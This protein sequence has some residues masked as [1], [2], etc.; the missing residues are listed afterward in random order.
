MKKYKYNY[1]LVGGGLFNAI[2]AYKA[3]QNN[4]KCLVVEKRSHLGGNVYCQTIE[5]INVH[6]YGAHIF[7]TKD[8]FVWEFMQTLCQFNHYINSPLA[9]YQD[10]IYN[11][12]FNMNTFYQLWGVK[13]P[14]EAMHKIES[15]QIEINNP[16]NL[17]EQALSLVGYD[18]Y[19]KLIKGYTEKQWGTEASKLPAFIINRIPLRFTFNNNYFEDPYQGI[20]IGG[21]TPI[22]EKCFAHSDIL[23]N[24]NFT[25]DRSLKDLAK[26]TIY[27][28][29]IDEYYSYKYGALEY[30]SLKFEERVLDTENFQGNAV[31]NYTEQNVPHTRI[32]EH[33]HFE[34]GTQPKTVISIE[35]PCKWDKKS[36]P[37]Y[38]INTQHNNLLYAKY[39]ELATKEDNIYFAGRLGTYQYNDMDKT[40]HDAL[41]LYE[42]LNQ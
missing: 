31:V 13:T 27:T 4:K 21:Y 19:E 14:K 1:L 29:M 36:E 11:L 9:K 40:V 20:P 26:T 24:T 22:I 12:P 33:K 17:E 38:P 3:T 34:F 18:I 35:Y 8:K 39:K 23:L 42:T 10:K 6:K 15:Q 32:L 5:G 7:H 41:K 30:R 28:G 37:Y 25:E 2:F 16:S